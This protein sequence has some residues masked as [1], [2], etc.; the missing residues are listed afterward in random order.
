MTDLNPEE[1]RSL[2]KLETLIP[3]MADNIK[4]IKRELKHHIEREDARCAHMEDKFATIGFMKGVKSNVDKLEG[5]LKKL[6][7]TLK[8][9]FAGIFVEK[10]VYIMLS[11]MT[12]GLLAMVGYIFSQS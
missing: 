7:E 8:K 10:I 1:A 3:M 11:L 5:D 9:S 12:T 2:T 4:E 6:P